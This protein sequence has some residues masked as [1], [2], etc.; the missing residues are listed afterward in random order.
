MWFQQRQ[1]RC[2]NYWFVAKERFRK[3]LL[4]ISESTVHF[5]IHSCRFVIRVN[6]IMSLNQTILPKYYIRICNKNVFYLELRFKEFSFTVTEKGR[7]VQTTFH[8]RVLKK[9]L[10]WRSSYGEICNLQTNG[11]NSV[12]H[13]NNFPSIKSMVEFS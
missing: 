8:S 1:E 12:K 9:I 6:V 7:E 2:R 3:S 11:Y 5:F 10:F 4:A 13:N